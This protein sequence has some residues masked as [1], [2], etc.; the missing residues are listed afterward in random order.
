MIKEGDLY[1]FKAPGHPVTIKVSEVERSG[2][3]VKL[4]GLITEA[5]DPAWVDFIGYAYESPFI[6]LPGVEG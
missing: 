1:K 2:R 4:F 5:E 3:Q 6:Y